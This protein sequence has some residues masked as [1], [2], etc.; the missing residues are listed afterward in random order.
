VRGPNLGN[1]HSKMRSPKIIGIKLE[2]CLK[3]A[4]AALNATDPPVCTSSPTEY[5]TVPFFKVLTKEAQILCLEIRDV[6]E[7]ATSD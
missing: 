1:L 7:Y 4:F 2:H 5:N 3:S 6:H